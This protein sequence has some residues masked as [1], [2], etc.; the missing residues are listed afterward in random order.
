MTTKAMDLKEIKAFLRS[1][2][3]EQMEILHIKQMIEDAQSEMLPKAIRYDLDKVQVCPDEKMSKICA[4]VVDWQEE[5]GRSIA[6][7]AQRRQLAENMIMQLE[8]EKEREVMRWY[9]LTTDNGQVL[10]WKQVA[11]RMN[12]YERH[13]KRIHGNALEHLVSKDGTK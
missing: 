4:A 2:R 13:I 1:I 3:C 10:T 8:D 6:I 11:I 5:L 9:Y 7:L 12:Y